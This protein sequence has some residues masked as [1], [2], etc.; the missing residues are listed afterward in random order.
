[1]RKVPE[2]YS[3]GGGRPGTPQPHAAAA[4]T[5]AATHTTVAMPRT[6]QTAAM[7]TRPTREQRA[8]NLIAHVMRDVIRHHR[9]AALARSIIELRRVVVMEDALLAV[10]AATLRREANERRARGGYLRLMGYRRYLRGRFLR[11]TQRERLARYE[12]N[13]TL[14]EDDAARLAREAREDADAEMFAR[15]NICR[16]GSGLGTCLNIDLPMRRQDDDDDAE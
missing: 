15:D 12:R 5:H 6:R 14:V 2:V 11:G 16:F 8:R 4:A 13:P 3:A 9:A 1:M 7:S 10:R